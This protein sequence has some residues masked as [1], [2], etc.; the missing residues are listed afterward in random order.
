MKFNAHDTNS[1]QPKYEDMRIASITADIIEKI[2]QSQMISVFSNDDFYT[3]FEEC[4]KR[5][6]E[7]LYLLGR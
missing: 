3:P 1:N 7:G 6:R 2:K 5:M 4:R